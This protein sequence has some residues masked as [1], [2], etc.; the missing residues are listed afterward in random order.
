LAKV[1]IQKKPL[2]KLPGHL[3]AIALMD[4]VR[5]NLDLIIGTMTTAGK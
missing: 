5:M 1:I 2:K 3:L 4:F